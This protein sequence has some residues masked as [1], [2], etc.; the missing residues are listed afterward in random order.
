MGNHFADIILPFAVKGQFTYA[1]PDEFSGEVMPGSRVLVQFGNKKLYSGIV[2]RLHDSP[3]LA[4]KTRVVLKVLDHRP[5]V[6]T[7]QLKFWNW[8]S[9]YY[10]CKPGEVMKAA[11]PSDLCLE[12]VATIPV[13][14]KYK[15]RTEIYV[16]LASDFAEADLNLILDKLEKAPA[17]SKIML[18]FL[19]LAGT[20]GGAE[21]IPVK[22]SQ[23][24]RDSGSSPDA[25]EALVKK[26]LMVP[27]KVN[28][29]RLHDLS[30]PVEPVRTLSQDQARALNEINDTLKVKD[31]VLLHG[32]TSSG[33]TEIYT[34]LI[35]D[36][37][38][39]GKQVL[40]L[41]PEIALTTQIIG[42]LRRHFGNLTGVYHSRFSQPEK[43]EIWKRVAGSEPGKDYKL[44]IGVRSAI[45]LP[46]RNLG[47]IVVDEEQD[48]SYKQ[49]DPAPRYHARD[50]AIILAGLHNAKTILG[51]ASPS[52]ESYNNALTGKYGLVEINERFGNVRLP[53]IVL[54]NSREAYRK[55]LMVSHFT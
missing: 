12:G 36:Q 29:D 51:T 20:N 24:L 33:K 25:F 22:K 49:H 1:I 46:F 8:L 41:L 52:V 16:R 45:F 30:L 21:A 3:P 9:D 37:L 32:V 7:V 4:F 42:R 40:Y 6:D 10:M 2:G 18:T 31:T 19:R 5:L 47:L 39:R 13:V 28:I 35:E 38:K 17:Q 54:A 23:L 26:K 43:V 50:A 48:G 27:V 11:L 14:E 15:P 44:I 55:K 34:H 53:E